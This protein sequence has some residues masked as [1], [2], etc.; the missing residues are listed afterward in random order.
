MVHRIRL[1]P[2][3]VERGLL[4]AGARSHHLLAGI[5]RRLHPA[6]HTRQERRQ[7]QRPHRRDRNLHPRTGERSRKHKNNQAQVNHCHA[8]GSEPAELLIGGAHHRRA[9]AHTL[10]QQVAHGPQQHLQQEPRHKHGGD[11]AH[12][13]LSERGA[14]HHERGGEHPQHQPDEPR[15]HRHGRELA[16]PFRAHSTH[17]NN[18]HHQQTRTVDE[19]ASPGGKPRPRHTPKNRAERRH[20]HAREH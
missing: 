2:R 11:G 15:P 1:N 17:H 16:G 9:A 5:H 6:H 12:I 10:R 20:Q 8:C 18:R 14:E 19:Q 7:P 13:K 3:P 4:T